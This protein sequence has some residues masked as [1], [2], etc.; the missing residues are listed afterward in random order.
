MKTTVFAFLSVFFIFTYSYSQSVPLG[1]SG[2]VAKIVQGQPQYKAG[3]DLFPITK[4]MTI[5]IDW[6]VITGGNQLV[7]LSLNNG[8]SIVVYANSEV[9][10]KADEPTKKELKLLQPKGFT[11]SRLPKLKDSNAFSV[12]TS[13]HTAGIR[14]T[15][16][17]VDVKGDGETQ[18]CVC[19][20]QVYVADG[21][22][23]EVTLKQGELV[24]GTSG[25]AM[26]PMKDKEFLK[27]PGVQHRN[28]IQCHRGGYSR[29]ELY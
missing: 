20:G 9:T 4:G 12:E 17:S 22:K 11:W 2:A 25:Q 5:E 8:G 18:V 3:A 23:H 7:I 15:A 10:L 1:S 26:N 19:E 24:R 16:F 27:H 14:G 21:D 28:C 29:I 6:T 13:S